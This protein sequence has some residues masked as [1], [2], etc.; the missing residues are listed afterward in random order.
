MFALTVSR[1]FA[2]MATA[3]PGPPF[4]FAPPAAPP[5][6]VTAPAVV[7][8]PPL[9]SSVTAPAAL[10][11]PPELPPEVVIA[12]VDKAPVV[13]ML[14]APPGRPALP[15]VEIVPPAP[16]VNE[17]ARPAPALSATANEPPESNTAALRTTPALVK[18]LTPPVPV[19]VIVAAGLT[20]IVE[21]ALSVRLFAPAQFRIGS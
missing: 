5:S 10:P 19:L 21:S 12:W 3:P 15:A 11:R 17:T 1:P 4:W 20:V 7:I 14:T 16:V 9:E 18:K 13:R 2:V 6:A 8:A